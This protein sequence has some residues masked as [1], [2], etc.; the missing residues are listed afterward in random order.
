M[1]SPAI[2]VLLTLFIHPPFRKCE[3]RSAKVRSKFEG[4]VDL[5]ADYGSPPGIV[6][7]GRRATRQSVLLS[8]RLRRTAVS[9]YHMPHGSPPVS[10]L[11]SSWRRP[12][13]A[14]RESAPVAAAAR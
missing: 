10:E 14:S 4:L 7:A 1:K 8:G 13:A 6:K 12:E 2:R 5:C 9:A 3:V 11:E